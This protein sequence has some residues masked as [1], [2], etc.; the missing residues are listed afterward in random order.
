MQSAQKFEYP[1][2]LTILM[3]CGFQEVFEKV[4]FISTPEGKA[5][6]EK[7]LKNGK[8]GKFQAFFKFH[9]KKAKIHF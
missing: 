1:T 4:K 3:P 8:K 9:R 6:S 2:D 5:K 7:V